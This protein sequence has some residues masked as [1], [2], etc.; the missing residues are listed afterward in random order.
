MKLKVILKEGLAS[1]KKNGG[2]KQ[3]LVCH[4]APP[5]TPNY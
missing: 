2:K 1:L 5:P 3:A 4:V